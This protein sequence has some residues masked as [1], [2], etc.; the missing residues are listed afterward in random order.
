MV[1]A[2]APDETRA[3]PSPFTAPTGDGVEL[4]RIGPGPTPPPTVVRLDTSNDV[5][6]GCRV[7][8]PPPRD[9]VK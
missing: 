7:V 4:A 2:P 3:P 8:M 1:P 6:E 9:E 5:V